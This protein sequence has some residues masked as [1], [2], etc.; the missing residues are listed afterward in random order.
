MSKQF[1]EHDDVATAGEEERADKKPT[2]DLVAAAG[3]ENLIRELVAEGAQFMGIDKQLAT[4]A[5]AL[6][7]LHTLLVLHERNELLKSAINHCQ[8]GIDCYEKVQDK[9]NECEEAL[10][11]ATAEMHERKESL[12]KA[13]DEMNK[14]SEVLKKATNCCNKA[15]EKVDEHNKC[16]KKAHDGCPAAVTIAAQQKKSE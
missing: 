7:M 5:A 3:D 13:L 10:K 12:N 16:L 15:A 8:A 14:C 2:L 11:T 6:R 1:A 9:M 4:S